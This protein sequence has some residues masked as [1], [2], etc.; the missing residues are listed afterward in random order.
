MDKNLVELVGNVTKD[1]EMK[2][3]KYCYVTVAVG[4]T[5][6]GGTDFISVKAFHEVAKSCADSLKKG[7]R[8]AITGHL[9][10]SSFIPKGKTEA[11]KAFRTDVVIETIRKIPRNGGEM[12]GAGGFIDDTAVSEEAA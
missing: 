6:S 7:D 11:E 9:A 2:S 12:N 5:R 1:V 10:S 3:D 4:R 8:V